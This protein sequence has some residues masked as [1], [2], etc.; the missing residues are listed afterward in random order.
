MSC[1]ASVGLF[2]HAA[3]TCRACAA[4][5]GDRGGAGGGGACCRAAEVGSIRP[6]SHACS[7][8]HH[9][10]YVTHCI[11]WRLPKPPD[12]SPNPHTH[13]PPTRTP[14]PGGP[15]LLIRLQLQQAAAEGGAGVVVF[16][17]E[18]DRHGGAQRQ[19]QV[20][21]LQGWGGV[22]EGGRTGGWLMVVG[23]GGGG[24]G[25]RGAGEGPVAARD[26]R[27][28]RTSQ[29]AQAAAGRT[30]RGI[31]NGRAW[32]TRRSSA[33][34]PSPGTTCRLQSVLPPTSLQVAVRVSPP[35]LNQPAG[36]S[37]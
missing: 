7:P 28:G 13:A 11:H 37:A 30:R 3:S 31:G 6:T 15:H 19:R 4:I 1:A 29:G 12:L 21:A 23:G 8:L 36:C 18:E 27:S 26:G 20:H 2:S 25:K 10:T 16:D 9:L 22:G 34:P 17:L 5:C 14:G 33:G 35:S 32:R 24:G